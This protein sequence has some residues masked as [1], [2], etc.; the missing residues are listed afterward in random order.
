MLKLFTPDLY[1]ESFDKIPLKKLI[2]MQKKLVLCDIDNTL[3]AHNEPLP[4][5]KVFAFIEAIRSHGMDICLISNNHRDRVEAFAEMIHLPFYSFAKKPLKGTYRQILHDYKLD[6]SDVIAI[7]DQLLTDVVGAKR[8]KMDVILT[9][10]LYQK[11]LLATKINRMFENFVFRRL[12]KR[13]KL[14]RGIFDE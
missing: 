6:V 12:K 5:E 4:N 3:V 8:M 1:Y 14:E 13:G 10:P 2:E 7:G 9:H 11:D